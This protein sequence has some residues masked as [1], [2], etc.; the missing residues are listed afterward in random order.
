MT[1]CVPADAGPV[2]APP[3]LRAF[4]DEVVDPTCDLVVAALILAAEHQA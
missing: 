3:G 1:P 4:A 2:E